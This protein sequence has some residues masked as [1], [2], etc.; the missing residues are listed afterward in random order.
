[1][2]I[3][4]YIEALEQHN[5]ALEQRI[6]ELEARVN[7][8]E[9]RLE[10]RVEEQANAI[11]ELEN[12]LSDLAMSE[13]EVEIEEEPEP[14]PIVKEPDPEPEPEPEPLPMV[15]VEPLPFA[16]E[17]PEPEPEPVKPEPVRQ[18]PVRQEPVRQEPPRAQQP[19]QG[20]LFGSMVT[21]LRHAISLGD[22]FLFQREIVAGGRAEWFQIGGPE[23][24]ADRFHGAWFG[25]R[26]QQI[27]PE[28]GDAEFQMTHAQPFRHGQLV[29]ERG[30]TQS[31][32]GKSVFHQRF[33]QSSRILKQSAPFL[34]R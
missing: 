14:E 21:D 30:Q 18:E 23:E 24:I 29:T 2:K 5:N 33:L 17:E 34:C 22:R 10:D 11:I 28:S 3:A 26:L 4:D 20:S 16:D 12:R 25:I 32:G 15:D 31:P 7:T 27:V 13:V 8:L 6:T 9:N 1:M 19:Q